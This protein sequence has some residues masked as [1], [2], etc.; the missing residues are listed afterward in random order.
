MKFFENVGT[1]DELKSEFRRLA[2]IHH[3]DRGGD[4]ETM[5]AINSIYEKLFPIMKA[6]HNQTASV[7]VHET[8]DS[9]RR[10]FYTENGWAGKNYNPYLST[11]EITQKIR[12]YVKRVFPDCK[13]SVSFSSFC[14]GSTIRV[15][16]MNGP[17]PALKN[18]SAHLVNPYW[19]E[20][21]AEMTE[22]GMA[23]MADVLDYINSYRMSDCDGMQEY[24][25]V[26]FWFNL[27]V[28]KWDCPYEVNSKLKKLNGNVSDNKISVA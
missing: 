15:H 28:G 17:Y 1:L 13:F 23:V 11:K 6:K 24:Y 25:D 26:N 4:T 8:A 19:I 21:D 22:W 7:K 9:Y 16:L 18:E 14:G 10:E 20:E 3:P 2:M 27:G 12:E 5:A